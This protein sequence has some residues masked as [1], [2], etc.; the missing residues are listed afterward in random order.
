MTTHGVERRLLQLIVA[1]VAIVVSAVANGAPPAPDPWT[2]VPP[3][4]T[5]C[6]AGQDGFAEKL[7]TARDALSAEMDRQE[8][9]NSEITDQL[10]EMDGAEKARRMQEYMMKNPQDAMKLMQ[11]NQAAGDSYTG[12]Q[13]QSEENRKKLEAELD[14]LHARYDAALA[15][16]LV[17][18]AAKFKELDARAQKALVTVGESWVY[19][20]W[21]VAEWNAINAK[22][23]A[24][25]ERVCREWWAASGPFHGWLNRYRDHLVQDEVPTRVAA[26]DAAAGFMARLVDKPA[27]SYQSTAA[28]AA[29]RDYM[30]HAYD[31]FSKRRSEPTKSR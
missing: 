24:T 13:L 1:I 21:A 15:S 10:K 4:P 5:G 26:D 12:T 27:A 19:A 7:G 16:A 8:R 2:R 3:F 20:P 11:Q 25:Y 9:A 22:E 31:I 28:M 29:T 6:Y 17:P 18:I 23:N 30:N 14:D